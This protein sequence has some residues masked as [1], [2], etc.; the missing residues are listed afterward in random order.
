MCGICGY[1]TFKSGIEEKRAVLAAMCDLLHHRG[2]D[3]GALYTKGNVGLGHRRLSIIDLSGG[4]Q[5]MSNEDGSLTVVFNGEIYNFPELRDEL[6]QKGYT[7]RTGSD[8]EVI[9]HG[10][11]A[12][13]DAVLQKLNGMFAFALWDA[14]RSR[15]L[16]ARDRLGKK[17]FYYHLGKEGF[18][19]S[20]EMKSILKESSVSREVN[21]EAVDK[22]FSYGYVP[23]PMTIFKSVS[24]LRPGH[25][26]VLE[27]GKVKVSQYWDVAYKPDPDCKTEDDYVDKLH[28]LM[29]AS[30]RRR[31]ISDVPLGAFLSGGID[32]SVV[33][34][35]MAGIS[36][37]AVKTFTIGFKEE[38]YSET[39]AARTV[40]DLFKTEHHEFTVEPDAV[41]LMPDLVWHFDEPFADS[42]AVPTYYVSKMA[43][44]Q[45]TVVL[46]G[47]GGDELF[48]GYNHY[49][50]MD[51]MQRYK[52]IPM[53]LR[54]AASGVARGLPM[55]ANGKFF[56]QALS[57]I[58]RRE[59]YDLIDIY[60][61]VKGDLMSADFRATL[62]G[63][64]PAES[65]LRYW[66]DAPGG[67]SISRMQY[68][69][70]KVYLPEDILTKVD[71]MSM[72]NSLETRAPL[73][74]YNVVEFA[75]SIPPDLQ[76]KDG[77][78]KYILRKMA[79]RFLPPA[80][81]DK[82]KQGFAIPRD[83]WFRKDLKQYAL[84]L[85]TSKR[86]SER[87]YFR[88]ANVRLLLDEH[89]KG[90]RDYSTWIWSLINFELWHRQFMD[91]D[92]RRV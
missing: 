3:E 78:G 67:P 90:R 29:Q 32:S 14:K 88:D 68:L 69:D 42:S 12:Y 57:E 31:L 77:R 79:A 22:F 72:A 60:P 50:Q 19:F 45:V 38:K 92:T 86:F 10:Y 43:R 26:L 51:G 46:S 65:S 27:D 34:G 35:L 39:A 24:K 87:G 20:S 47:D 13:G 66:T 25:F 8:T 2:P 76:R 85:L 49:R 84:D 33:V 17:P 81:L 54:Q 7:F 74:D 73:L 61:P 44:S 5:P 52:N 9:L 6:R 63:L 75:A 48:A 59:R 58:E 36:T 62:K 83:Q 21:P 18:I 23:A 15:L 30:V 64:A 71:R 70:T 40:S 91:A 28:G 56:L 55:G 41:S 82:K 4:K 11:H 1:I 53:F 80:I 37:S 16:A 89:I